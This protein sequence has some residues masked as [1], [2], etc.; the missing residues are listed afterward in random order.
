MYT[1]IPFTFFLLSSHKALQWNLMENFDQWETH[2]EVRL[3][4]VAEELI[5]MHYNKRVSELS[6]E[7]IQEL[8][9]FAFMHNNS[10]LCYG[11]RRNIRR[12]EKAHKT[13][14]DGGEYLK[15]LNLREGED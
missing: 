5:E 1:K 15:E 11:L 14:V 8:D 10:V 12:W 6:K 2:M 13:T 7:E 4:I 3:T 9:N